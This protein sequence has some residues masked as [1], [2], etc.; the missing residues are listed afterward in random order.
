VQIVTWPAYLAG[1][2][3]AIRRRRRLS[4]V[5]WGPDA[6]VASWERVE[7]IERETGAELRCTHEVEFGDVPLAPVAW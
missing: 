4:A 2:E 6:T 7:E 5:V 1:C 3:R